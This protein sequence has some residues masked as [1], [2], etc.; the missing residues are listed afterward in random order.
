LRGQSARQLRRAA[1]KIP[2][3]PDTAYKEINIQ[4]G[5]KLYIGPEGPAISV[6]IRTSTIELTKS[7]RRS[8][9]KSMKKAYYEGR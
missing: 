6:P 9:Y 3:I 1:Y 7:C 5:P 8:W 4:E 2:G